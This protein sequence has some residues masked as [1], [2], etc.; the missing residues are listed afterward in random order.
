MTLGG[1]PAPEELKVIATAFGF[2]VFVVMLL[3]WVPEL[4]SGA[5]TIKLVAQTPSAWPSSRPCDAAP[6]RSSREGRAKKRV[7]RLRR[8]ELRHDICVGL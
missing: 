3:T 4:I 8:M 7:E 1:H 6:F 5:E 2:F